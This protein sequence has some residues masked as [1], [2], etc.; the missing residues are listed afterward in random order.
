IAKQRFYKDMQANKPD[1]ILVPLFPEYS[2]T[3]GADMRGFA[4]SLVV[5]DYA[6]EGCGYNY[7]IYKLKR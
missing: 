1:L 4:D 7:N 5:K 6:L 2:Q 3:V